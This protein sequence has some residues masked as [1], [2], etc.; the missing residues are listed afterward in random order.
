MRFQATTTTTMFITLSLIG[1]AQIANAHLL[2]VEEQNIIRSGDFNAYGQEILHSEPKPWKRTDG[3]ASWDAPHEI[4]FPLMDSQA[5]FSWLDPDD[6][7]VYQFTV[8]LNDVAQGVALGFGG[9]FVIAA[10]IP[11]ACNQ[12]KNHYPAIALVAPFGTAPVQDPSF[13]DLPFEVP[14]GHGVLPVFNTQ[15]QGNEQR[16]IF[17]LPDEDTEIPLNLSWYL[18]NGC[19]TEPF[20]NCSQSDTLATPVFAPFTTAYFVVWNPAGNS[21]DYTLN[22]GVDESNFQSFQNIDDLVRDNNH[23]HTPCTGPYPGH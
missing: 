14:P 7:D 20:F 11:P 13:F 17:V 1:F 6:V 18:P 21:I 4:K 23:L 19:V 15:A 5:I 10:P 2:D 22:L 12:T 3:D 9:A 8:T 16:P